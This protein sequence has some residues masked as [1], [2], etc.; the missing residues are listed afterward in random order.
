MENKVDMFLNPMLSFFTILF[1]KYLRKISEL[2]GTKF[3]SKLIK[4]PF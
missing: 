2:S 1:H 3:F 4:M